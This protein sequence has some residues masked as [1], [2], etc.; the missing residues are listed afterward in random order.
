MARSWKFLL[1][2]SFYS[3]REIWD[4]KDGGKDLPWTAVSCAVCCGLMAEDRMMVVKYYNLARI[5]SFFRANVGCPS[6][7]PN[8]NIFP[9][10]FN[11]FFSASTHSLDTL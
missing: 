8:F 4:N 11:W 6:P 5:Y 1:E 7:M 10:L 3:L 2:P 9:I